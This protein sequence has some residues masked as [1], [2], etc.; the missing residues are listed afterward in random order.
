[1]ACDTVFDAFRQATEHLDQ[2]LLKRASWRSIF[3]NLIQKAEYPR[4][5]G[6]NLRVFTIER[7]GPT[8]DVNTWPRVAFSNGDAGSCDSTWND[9]QYG[10]TERGYAPEQYSLRGPTICSDDLIYNWNTDQFLMGYIMAIAKHSEQEL[11]NRYEAIYGHFVDKNVEDGSFTKTEGNQGDLP[12]GG[13]ALTGMTN[14]TCELNFEN[15]ET[16]AVELIQEGATDPD[17][18]GWITWGEM[19][20]VFPLYI[21]L[22]AS[23]RFLRSNT[24]IRQDYRDADSSM[25]DAARLLKR[26]GATRIIGNFRHVPNLFPPRYHWQPTGGGLGHFVRVPTWRNVNTSKGVSQEINQTWRDAPIEAAYVLTPWVYKSRLVRPVNAAA[27]LSWDPKSYFGEW[28]FRTGGA[29][30]TAAGADCY[31]PLGKLGRHFGEYKHAPEPLYPKYGRM[32]FFRRCSDTTC[33][34]CAS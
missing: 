11:A 24:N 25:G 4:G 31:D 1:M 13:P 28:Q 17:S 10:H 5:A 27:G 20:P 19:G 26:V 22:E 12:T 33:A 30:I 34:T 32:I 16:V 15:L 2:D 21:G 6:L 18:N 8:S 14:P 9:V 7:S 23:Q 29:L 3:F